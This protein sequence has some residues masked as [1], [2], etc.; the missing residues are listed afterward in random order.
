MRSTLHFIEDSEGTIFAEAVGIAQ[1][2][3]PDKSTKR[4]LKI[5]VKKER[6]E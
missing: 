5:T 2:V 1:R 6:T 4:L 3:A